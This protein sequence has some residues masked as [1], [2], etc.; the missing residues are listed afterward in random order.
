MSSDINK[1]HNT[2]KNLQTEYVR[3]KTTVVRGPRNKLYY[4]GE[5]ICS[6]ED[7]NEAIKVADIWA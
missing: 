6:F 1:V 5:F 7:F 4:L 2:R 3:G